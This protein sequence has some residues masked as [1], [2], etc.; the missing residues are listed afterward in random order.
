[1]KKL[2]VLIV[3]DVNDEGLDWEVM[4]KHREFQVASRS[5]QEILSSPMLANGEDLVII[6]ADNP[7]RA[8][9]L[10]TVLRTRYSG[11]VLL[12]APHHDERDIIAGYHAGAND[13]LVKPRSMRVLRAKVSMWITRIV[14]ARIVSS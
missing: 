2:Q 3:Q 6:E 9:T 1:M 4:L 8:I 13:Y 12:Y 11:V 5:S 10:C 14:K 7:Q